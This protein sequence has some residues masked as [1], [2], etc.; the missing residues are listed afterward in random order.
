MDHDS[1]IAVA[2]DLEYLSQWGSDISNADIRRGTAILRRLLV[3]DAYGAAWR[4]IGQPKQPSIPAVD[5]ALMLGNQ[6][7]QVVFALAGGALFRGVQMACMMM[8]KGTVPLG[9]APPVP[10]REDGY[11][12]ERMFTLSEYLSS[13]SGVVD[14]RS[15]NRREVIK[16][17]A[18]IKGGVHLNA[19]Q[20]KLEEKLIAKLGKIERKIMVHSTD[21]LLVEAVAIAQS[22]G[23]SKDA[24]LTIHTIHSLSAPNP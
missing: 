5:L 23:N 24:R 7:N 1:L 16:Y 15:F 18:N 11:P 20:R 4:A 19:Q 3:E 9:G 17:L 8:N 14:G 6:A 10:I 22:V 21:G 13:A 12:F 2:E